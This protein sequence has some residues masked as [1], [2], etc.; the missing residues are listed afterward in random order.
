MGES[1]FAG[2]AGYFPKY[3]H[4]EGVFWLYPP[5]AHLCYNPNVNMQCKVK[6]SIAFH[7]SI[8]EC[9]EQLLFSDSIPLHLS[10]NRKSSTE[11]SKVGI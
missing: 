5:L 8:V 3:F 2:Q 10:V 9:T 4:R 7:T 6:Q 1:G 11:V